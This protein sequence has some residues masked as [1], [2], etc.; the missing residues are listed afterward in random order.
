MGKYWLKIRKLGKI[1]F[2]LL[3]TFL[4]GVLFSLLSSLML[5]IIDSDFSLSR[6]YSPAALGMLVGAFL[7]GL[8]FGVS[9]WYSKEKK[10]K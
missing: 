1:K 4:F 8:L 7:G 2:I 3:Y 5:M 9:L 10:M 6:L